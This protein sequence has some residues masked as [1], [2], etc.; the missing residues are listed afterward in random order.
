[1]G[2]R[3]FGKSIKTLGTSMMECKVVVDVKTK[4]G[5]QLSTRF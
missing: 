1:M 5:I 2:E 3:D 4:Q